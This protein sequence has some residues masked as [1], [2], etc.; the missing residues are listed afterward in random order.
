[1]PTLSAFERCNRSAHVVWD[2]VVLTGLVVD[3][4]EHAA[5]TSDRYTLPGHAVLH[6][7]A[8]YPKPGDQ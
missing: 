1:M 4:D 5:P 7:E 8:S 3:E 6:D 2:T